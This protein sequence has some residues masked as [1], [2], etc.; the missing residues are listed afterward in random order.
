MSAEESQ[1]LESRRQMVEEVCRL[2]GMPPHKVGM[3][4]GAT[5]SNI[6]EQ[7]RSYVD[8]TLMAITR[9]IEEALEQDLLFAGEIGNYKFAFDFNELLRGN[10]KD[11]VAAQAQAIQNG[12]LSVNE[13]RAEDNR[14]PVPGGDV[15]RV[16]MNMAALTEV[17]QPINGETPDQEEDA[18]GGTE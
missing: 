1:L 8:D 4:D 15:Y 6:E 16:Q 5:F 10:R 12:L 7:S 14:P 9:P 2:F 3:L 11:R 18:Q 13:A 17:N